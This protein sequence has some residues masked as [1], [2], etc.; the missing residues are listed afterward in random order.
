[1]ISKLSANRLKRSCFMSHKNDISI[2]VV[3]HNHANFIGKLISS[4]E[5]FGY[6]N[7]Y[8]CEAA[9]NDN[10]HD[11]VSGS[12]FK[13]NILKKNVLEG[14]SKNNND[15]I[16]HFKLK[17]KYFLLLNPDVY[18]DEDFIVTLYKKMEQDSQIGISTPLIY[19][20]DKTIQTTWKEFPG[21]IQVLKKRMGLTNAI[22]ER[23]MQT[24]DIDWCLGACM[25][26]SHRLLKENNTLLD[27]RYRLYCEDVDICFEARQEQLKVVGVKEAYAYHH[28]SELS[29]KRIFSKYN[30]WNIVSIFKFAFKWN[31]K[32]L[33]K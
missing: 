12:I 19:Y 23:Q 33:A 30:N 16:R 10:T 18:F 28:L 1:M 27:E 7:T 29:S 25:L 17:T 11:I 5:K 13:S 6:H 24:P 4:L 21:V 20:P 3:T 2:L 15:L 31:W 9:S 14:F 8:F 32:Y 26:I 22:N